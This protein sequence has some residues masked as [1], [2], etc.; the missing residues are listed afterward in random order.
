MHVT[1]LGC[2]AFAVEAEGRRL[3]LDPFATRCALHRAA[4]APLEP[5][6]AR[7]DRW[8]PRADYV[9]CG[10]AH[11]D[12]A[13]DAPTIARRD[14]ALLVGSPT[15]CRIARASGVPEGQLR[16]VPP[17]GLRLALGPFK[18]RLVPAVH[19]RWAFGRMLFSGC[20]SEEPRL[21][22]RAAGWVDGGVFGIHVEAAGASLYHLGSAG[23]VDGA[24]QGLQAD[25]VLACLAGRRFTPGYLE[26]LVLA[27]QPRLVVAS[28]FDD[29]FRPLG[30]PLR[31]LPGTGIDSFTREVEG[32]GAAP[33]VP[34]HL[35]SF[36][37]ERR[38][39]SASPS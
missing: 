26:R 16:E 13:L 30:R 34:G 1:W 21:P 2:A 25:A 3:L 39:R 20:L 28:H 15:L 6:H 22:M 29:F 23:I 12:H 7:I 9:V 4:L 11:Y 19:G 17:D 37:L 35:D 18:I 24:L 31:H 36:A 38:A 33:L 8:I 10:H 5:D 14:G 27:L 32:L